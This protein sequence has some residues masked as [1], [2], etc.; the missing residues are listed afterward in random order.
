LGAE[1]L[2]NMT[3]KL[4]LAI[5]IALSFVLIPAAAEA[6][7]TDDERTL[8]HFKTVL[9]PQAYRTQDVGLLGKLLHPGFQMI[10]GEGERSTR[11]QELDWVAENA[12]DPG[13]FEYRIERLD[14][15][16]GNTAVIDGMGVAAKYSYRSS[17]VLI[18]E[19]GRWRAVAS[20]VSGYRER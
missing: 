10:D 8:R 1:T 15:Y 2:E 17:N 3:D 7:T 16:G 12:W 13:T 4:R 19:D 5:L 18:K 6:E 11:Q 20:H 14:I 9:W